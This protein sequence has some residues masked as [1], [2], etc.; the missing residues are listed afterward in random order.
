MAVGDEEEE[1]EYGKV[2]LAP[3]NVPRTAYN[4]FE[5]ET[6]SINVFMPTSQN[7]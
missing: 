2:Y 4:L 7:S 1:F 6:C 5:E 3:P